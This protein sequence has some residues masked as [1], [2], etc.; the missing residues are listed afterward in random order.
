M[1]TREFAALLTLAVT[2]S[3]CSFYVGPHGL[4][5]SLGDSTLTVT[6]KEQHEVVKAE[7]GPLSEGSAKNVGTIIGGAIA[8]LMRPPPP[9]AAPAEHTHP[10]Y[11]W[12]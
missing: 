6:D 8:W 5:S 1:R 9:A 11:E 4:A 10:E 2:V 7:T 3:G 12:E